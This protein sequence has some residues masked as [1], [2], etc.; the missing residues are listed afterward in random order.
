MDFNRWLQSRLSVHGLPVDVD[1]DWGRSSIE[2]LKTFQKRQGLRVTGFAGSATVGALRIDPGAPEPSQAAPA[3]VETMPPW[4]AEMNRRS[5]L[6]EVRDKRT[7][8]DF[9]KV[10]RFLGDPGNLPWCGDAVESCI[11]KVL[12]TEPLPSNPFWAQAWAS[13]GI[14][15]GG[16]AVGSIG[17]IRWNAK[18]GHVGIVAGVDGD[19]V[20]LLGGNQ[21]NSINIASFARSK[22]VAFR[23]PKTFPLKS[24]PALKGHTIAIN[25]EGATR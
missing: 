23:W 3:P 14:D 11:A 24:Y 10:G 20:N 5:G 25:T 8:I 4:M 7:L 12:T 2:A 15:A 9:L 22:F 17:V 18:S 6:H 1:G 16:P 13:F 19:R 21:S